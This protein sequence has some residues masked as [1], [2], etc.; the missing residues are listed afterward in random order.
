MQ[1]MKADI[2]T[3][4]LAFRESF[5][6]EASST[7]ADSEYSAVLHVILYYLWRGCSLSREAGITGKTDPKASL[8][9]QSAYEAALTILQLIRI[10]YHADAATL[11]RALMERIAIIGYIGEKRHLI[12]RYFQDELSP[13][14]EALSWAKKKSLPNWMIL[15]STLSGVA[16]S[17]IMGPAAHINNC[18]EIGNAFRLATEKYPSG[19]NMIEE[20]LGLTVYSLLALDT[21]ALEL[22]QNSSVKPFPNDPGMAQNVGNKDAKEFVDFLQKLVDR[23]GKYS[24]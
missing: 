12:A 5:F 11:L 13:Y 8:I 9:A 21:L 2:I 6:A 19:S 22:I 23:Y 1:I 7:K 17:T 20:L 3:N 14:K 24:K 18:T 16:H 10:G 4:P 15:Y